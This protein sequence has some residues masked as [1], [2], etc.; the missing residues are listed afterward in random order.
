MNKI[1]LLVLA[2]LPGSDRFRSG[3]HADF[4]FVASAG[5][6]KFNAG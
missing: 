1:V 2:I 5:S 3:S 4:Q 6:F